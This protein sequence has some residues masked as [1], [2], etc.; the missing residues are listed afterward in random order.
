ML[1]INIC[2]F[3]ERM[4]RNGHSCEPKPQEPQAAQKAPKHKDHER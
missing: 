2:E 4:E 3:A 1:R